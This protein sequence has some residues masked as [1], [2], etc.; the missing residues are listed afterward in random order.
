MLKQSQCS[1][2]FGPFRVDPVERLLLREGHPVPIKAKIFDTLL[3]LIQNHGHLIEKADV[4][5]ALWGDSFVEESNL[6]VSMSL[7]RKALGDDANE[8]KYIQ[9]VPRR[10][11]RFVGDVREVMETE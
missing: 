4:M 7:L 5:K 9:T 10:G 8:Q 11:Y 6:T 3:F 1:Y 2:E